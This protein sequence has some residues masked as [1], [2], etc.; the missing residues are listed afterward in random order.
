MQKISIDIETYC[1]ADLGSVGV[2]RY[3][4]DKSFEVLLFAYAVDDGPVQVVDLACGELIPAVI[5]EALKND[6]VL[7]WA[8]NA[9]F[10]RVCLS[11][12]LGMPT[13]TYLDSESW[14]CSMVWGATLG[15]PIGLARIG[16]ILNL[17]KQK[18]SEGADLIRFFCQPQKNGVRNLPLKNL[19]LWQRFKSYNIRDVET[20]QA[21]QNKLSRFPVPDF[22]WEEYA[23]DQRIND[24]G[25]RIDQELVEAC[26]E[27][28]AVI[29]N[30]ITSELKALTGLENPNSVLQLLG[31]LEKHGVTAA[32]LGK[33][34]VKELIDSTT[35]TK[36][37]RVLQ[38]RLLSAKSAVKKF[39]AMQ[40]TVC[41]D[42]RC[43]GM[44]LFYGAPRTGRWSG[45][46]VQ[47]Q[48]LKRNDI[49]N[50]AQIRDLVKTRNTDGLSLLYDDE[51]E[52]IAQLVRTA[53]IAKPGTRF[54]VADF[55]AI[56]ARVIAWLAGEAWR[57]KV[58]ADGGDIYCAS[59]SQMF[60]V[61]VVK[62]GINGHLRQKGKIAELALG[63]GGSVGALKAMNALKMGLKEEELKPLVDAW[64][65]SNLKICALWWAVDK[66]VKAAI[67]NA[68]DVQRTH[69]LSFQKVA[70]MLRIKLPSGRCLTYPKIELKDA[71]I[72]YFGGSTGSNAWARI[73]SYGPK[74]V[75]NI[76]QAIA[77]DLLCNAMKKLSEYNIV[78]HVHDELII[79]APDSLTLDYVCQRMSITPDWARGLL[80]RADGYETQ[81]YLKD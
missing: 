37:K 31:F 28:D 15:L 61:P 54:I 77:R 67:T 47:L 30:R 11:K 10:E 12:M 6:V 7:K 46:Q 73:E 23:I 9:N 35:N 79:E 71:C 69:G 41:S 63:Y 16:A 72:T 48:N 2:Y 53:F 5:V 21:I 65:S 80:L 14:R 29:Q 13:G 51:L 76:T 44:F 59:A 55:S 60:K 22:V 19:E 58:F 78:M 20:E 66:A 70:G 81:F 57:M 50:I 32:K 25:V 42:L 68:G 75:E 40:R 39:A 26:I 4:D 24:R 33:D 38:L 62:H 52:V 18:L 8:Y 3:A 1:E 64:R 56:E 43:R 34:Q 36:I 49:A 27:F 17:D 45:R 74:F